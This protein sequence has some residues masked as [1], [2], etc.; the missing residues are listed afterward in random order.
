MKLTGKLGLGALLLLPV[1]AAEKPRVMFGVVPDAALEQNGLG[2]RAV[3]PASPAQAAG[4]QVGDVILALNGTAVSSKEEMRAVLQRL[5][6]GDVLRVE[7]LQNGDRRVLDVPLVERP[8]RQQKAAASPD[9]AVGGDRVLRPLVVDPGIRKAMREHRRAIVAQL[10]ALPG[11]FVPMEV[12][13]HLQ[14]IRHLARDANPR[15]RGW[16]S[17]EAGEVTLQ[18][19]DAQGIMV[20]HG[21]SNQLTLTVYDAAG[22]ETHKWRLNTPEAR[23]EIPQE[24]IERLQKLR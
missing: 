3:R 24:L 18:F 12:S 15:G 14:A 20:L 16:M 22:N 2:V 7:V 8:A 11:G 9:A 19:K 5:A 21:A 4:L 17:G 13:D 23:A 10:A 1:L 6:P